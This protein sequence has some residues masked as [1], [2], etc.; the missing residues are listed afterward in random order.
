M[1]EGKQKDAGPEDEEQPTEEVLEEVGDDFDDFAEEGDDDFGDFDEAD[2]TP[3]PEPQPTPQTEPT[4]ILA[5]LVWGYARN[6][7]STNIVTACPRLLF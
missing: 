4:N 3:M 5:D 6:R 1:W 7:V 2:E